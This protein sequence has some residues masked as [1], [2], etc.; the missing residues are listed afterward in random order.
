MVTQSDTPRN[1]GDRDAPHMTP[2]TPAEDIRTVLLNEISWGAVIAGVAVALVMQLLLNMLGIGI[3]VATLDPM[4]GDSPEARTF[5]I[6]AGIWWTVSGII[7]AFTGGY[8]A[9]RLAGRPKP[10]TAGWHGLCAWAVSTLLVVGLM[11]GTAS[12]VIGGAL[13]LVAGAA[14]GLGRTATTAAQ[15]AIPTIAQT[16]DPFAGIEQSL[17]AATGGED[18]AALRDAAI[19]AVRG[20]VTGDEAQAADARER[21]AQALARMQNISID[22]ARTRVANYEQQYRQAVDRA[23]QRAKEVA[24][25]AT[26]IISRAALFGFFALALGAIAGWFGGR[27]GAVDSTITSAILRRRRSVA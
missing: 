19:A 13:N 6:V 26:K 20:V 7:A 8:A 2:V 11:A 23:R 27:A 24:D 22:E 21:A 12:T 18:P 17:R 16:T 10:E 25:A 4:T 5:S 1:R 3:G 15:T 9:G 14:G